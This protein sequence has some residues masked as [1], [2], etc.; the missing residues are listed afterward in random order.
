[1]PYPYELMKSKI[2]ARFIL[3]DKSFDTKIFEN[4]DEFSSWYDF[5]TD[6]YIEREKDLPKHCKNRIEVYQI[7]Y[8]GE[9]ILLSTWHF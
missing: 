4:F 5:T 1:M 6:L 2:M 3:N 8:N 9:K 7:F